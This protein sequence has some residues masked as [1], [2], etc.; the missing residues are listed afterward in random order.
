MLCDVAQRAGSTCRRQLHRQASIARVARFCVMNCS[1]LVEEIV[2][3]IRLATVRVPHLSD[4]RALI[5]GL[6]HRSTWAYAVELLLQAAET[7]NRNDLTGPWTQMSHAYEVTFGG[8]RHN[9][10]SH[11]VNCGFQPRRCGGPIHMTNSVSLA[12]F[13]A[14]LRAA[15]RTS[16]T[17]GMD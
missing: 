7:G 13:P 16:P 14:L 15:M 5:L 11:D 3:R 9:E 4:A 12:G 6:Q 17:I 2:E 1:E 8:H 10:T